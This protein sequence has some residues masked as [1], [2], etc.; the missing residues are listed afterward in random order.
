M[1]WRCGSSSR[2]PA[3]QA[4]S[5]KKE[6]THKK[7]RIILFYLEKLSKMGRATLT[8]GRLVISRGKWGVRSVVVEETVTVKTTECQKV[9]NLQR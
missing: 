4:Q 6:A 3:L 1:G 7:L 8:E 5:R 2:A 9:L